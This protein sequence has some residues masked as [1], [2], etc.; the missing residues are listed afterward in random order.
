[1]RELVLNKLKD[2]IA[3]TEGYGIMREIDDEENLITD[4]D[5]LDDMSDEELLAIFEL[6]VGFQG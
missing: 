1:M 6:T 2:F 3:D 5:E 4:P